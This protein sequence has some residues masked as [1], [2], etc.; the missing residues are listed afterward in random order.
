MSAVE[1]V[2]CVVLRHPA[3]RTGKGRMEGRIYMVKVGGEE[4]GFVGPDLC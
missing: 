2:S 3:Q 4:G 1:K